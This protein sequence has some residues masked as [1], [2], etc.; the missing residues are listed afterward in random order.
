[1]LGYWDNGFRHISNG[2]RPLRH[3]NDCT[4]LRLRTLDSPLHQEIFAALGFVPVFLDTKDLADAVARRTVDA[5]ENPLTNLVNFGLYHTH[6]H[7]SLTS[8]FFGVA[9][10]LVNRAWFD[11]LAPATQVGL[12]IIADETTKR[13]RALAMAED[14]RCLDILR[15]DGV[16]IVPAEEINWNAFRT[17]VQPVV[18]REIAR[19]GG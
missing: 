19:L 14:A 4:G 6:R 16:A 5:Q 11:A 18:E 7:V 17:A 3:P 10:L 2:L 12:R 9:L 8:H 1:V 15:S 13:Q